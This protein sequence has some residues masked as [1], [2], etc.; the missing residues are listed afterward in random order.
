MKKNYCFYTFIFIATLCDWTQLQALEGLGVMRAQ[1]A[2]QMDLVDSAKAQKKAAKQK[3]EGTLK[4]FEEV[5]TKIVKLEEKQKK[6]GKKKTLSSKDQ[7]KKTA[8][9]T[10]LASLAVKREQVRTQAEQETKDLVLKDFAKAQAKQIKAQEELNDA[11]T[12]QDELRRQSDRDDLAVE[13]LT[14]KLSE[15]T[16]QASQGGQVG[17]EVLSTRTK[18]DQAKKTAAESNTAWKKSFD[19]VSEKEKALKKA[20]KEFEKSD[21]YRARLESEGIKIEAP[22]S[23][24]QRFKDF[25]RENTAT[26]TA[27]MLVATGVSAVISG[28]IRATTQHGV[29]QALEA[30]EKEEEEEEDTTGQETISLEAGD[31]NEPETIDSG[32]DDKIVDEEKGKVSAEEETTVVDQPQDLLDLPKEAVMEPDDIKEKPIQEKSVTTK[33]EDV[34]RFFE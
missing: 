9:E 12:R 18:L 26:I 4:D 16:L 8:L 19:D 3:L 30:R 7:E 10:D 6:I 5:D 17:L 33:E 34:A 32:Q 27:P 21:A 13:G 2:A 24:T 23:K 20:N 14:K 1:Q 15:L 28:G 31:E 29:E 11:N 25:V 22:K